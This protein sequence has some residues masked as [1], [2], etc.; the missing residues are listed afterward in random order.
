MATTGTANAIGRYCGCWAATTAAG[1]IAA[2]M[3]RRWEP[4]VILVLLAGLV[5]AAALLSSTDI[6]AQNPA[7]VAQ[8]APRPLEFEL[9]DL[10]DGWI[11]VRYPGWRTIQFRPKNATGMSAYRAGTGIESRHDYVQLL[12]GAAQWRVDCPSAERA[13]SFMSFIRAHSR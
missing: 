1:I 2:N 12:I 3:P 11:E 13:K 9:I 6:P 10:G 4:M 7:L 8:P 5:A